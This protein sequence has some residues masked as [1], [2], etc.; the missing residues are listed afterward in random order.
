M[1]ISRTHPCNSFGWLYLEGGENRRALDAQSNFVDKQLALDKNASG[2]PAEFREWSI[3][4]VR[5]LAQQ[6]EVAR[7]IEQRRA[8][9]QRQ[10][11]RLDADEAQ[12]AL[13]HHRQVQAVERDLALL[14]EVLPPPVTITDA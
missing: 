2:E 9:L 6:P 13:A 8:N 14:D 10:L 11:D 12:R 1:S 5:A 7:Q 3:R 4:Q